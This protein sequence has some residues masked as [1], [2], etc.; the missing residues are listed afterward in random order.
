MNTAKRFVTRL[1]AVTLAV[2]VCFLSSCTPKKIDIEEYPGFEPT[3]ETS[4]ENPDVK[5]D[6]PNEDYVEYPGGMT[7]KEFADFIAIPD[8]FEETDKFHFCYKAIPEY[9]AR[10]YREKP[11]IIY[12]AKEMMEAVYN[13]QMEFDIPPENEL[14][15]EENSLAESL[16][17][18]SC[19]LVES[20]SIGYAEDDPLKYYVTYCSKVEITDSAYDSEGNL[21]VENMSYSYL[22]EDEAIKYV[23]DFS[24]YISSLIDRNVS[25]EDSDMEKAAKIYA[26]LTKE[27]S[28]R[29]R[30]DVEDKQFYDSEADFWESLAE[31]TFLVEDIINDK[32]TTQPRLALL[33]QY[34]LTQLN[35]ECMTVSSSGAYHSQGIEE[36]DKEMGTRGRNIWNVVVVDGKAY[37]CDLAYEI[38]T[39]EYDKSMSADVEPQMKYFGMSDSTRSQSF[40]V[41]DRSSIYY[42]NPDPWEEESGPKNMVPECVS[43]Y[44][45]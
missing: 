3:E 24:D 20:C 16:A 19:P 41:S 27:I 35:I 14:N 8:P 5:E 30:R 15:W 13:G 32:A 34:I 43:D 18:M 22:D 37:N 25:A 9:Y 33:Y 11:Q 45:H 7:D 44:K 4:T 6:I 38:L 12:V 21:V 17:K 36:L 28:Y 10:Q 39:Y 40:T 29:E 31:Q 2:G 23:N 1:T 26:A 42:Y